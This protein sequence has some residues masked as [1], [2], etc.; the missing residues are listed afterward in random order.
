MFDAEHALVLEVVLN[1]HVLFLKL[2]G[3]GLFLFNMLLFSHCLLFFLVSNEGLDGE[4]NFLVG[5]THLD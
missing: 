2:L 4:G 3:I 5:E 1:L